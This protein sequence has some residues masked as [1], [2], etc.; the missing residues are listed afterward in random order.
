LLGVHSAIYEY[1]KANVGLV[2]TPCQ[3]R[4]ARR[5]QTS[6]LGNQRLA[7]AMTLTIGL[8][9][10][11]SYGHS[12]LMESYLAS[13]GIDPTSV[14]KVGI[15]KG[16]FIAWKNEQELLRVPLKETDQYVR[17]SCKHCDDFT[18]EFADISVGGVG[19]PTGFSTVIART[20][21]GLDILKDAEKEDYLELREL[22]ATEKGYQTVTKMTQI[23]RNRKAAPPQSSVNLS[24]PP[25]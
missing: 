13:K 15:K 25:Q 23:K 5:I 7:K 1:G 24:A 20:K 18:A 14:T 11:E 9:C 12:K 19:C 17:N 2:G 4:A 21:K 16:S 22:P 6:P 8:F 10:M 3:I